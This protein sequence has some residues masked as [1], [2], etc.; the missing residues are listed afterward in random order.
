[1]ADDSA[2]FAGAVR[3][4]L[5]FA[6]YDRRAQARARAE[7]FTWPTAVTGMLSALQAS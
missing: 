5:A 4:L 2:A 3:G 7:Q 6:E 1:V